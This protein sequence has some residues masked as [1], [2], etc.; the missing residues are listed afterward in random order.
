VKHHVLGTLVRVTEPAPILTVAEAKAQC[1]VLHDDD[2]AK[3]DSLIQTATDWLDGT[4]GYLGRSLGPQTWDWLI[5]GWDWP[6]WITP[7]SLSRPFQDPH[8]RGL[9]VPLPPLISVA[10]IAYID[11]AGHPATWTDYTLHAVRAP[12][13]AGVI[14][15]AFGRF[16]PPVQ[17]S[18]EA[19]RIRF[20]AGYIRSD[21]ASPPTIVEAVP[22]TIK[23]AMLLTIAD[24]YASRETFVDSRSAAIPITATIDNLLSLYHR[25]LVG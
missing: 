24:L 18:A 11:T 23:A 5:D 4:E 3:F 10:E 17:R 13:R 22:Y 14:R 16:W 15:P 20:T 19:V 8:H 9:V 2:D 1:N 25:N 6:H 12:I 7:E 21:G